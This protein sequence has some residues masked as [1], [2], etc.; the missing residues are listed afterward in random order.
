MTIRNKK[1]N[2]VLISKINTAILK[3]LTHVKPKLTTVFALTLILALCVPV[4]ILPLASAHSPAWKIQTWAYVAAAPNPVG[5]GQK[6]LI[7]GFSSMVLPSAAATNDI[8]FH[9]LQLKITKPDNTT[10]T[11]NLPNGDSTSTAYSSYTPD[12]VGTYSIIFTYPDLYFKWNDT[13]AL[14]TWTGDTFTGATSRPLKLVVQEEPLPQPIDSYP[15]PTEYWTRPIEGQNTYW[16]TVSSNWL[17]SADFS[18]TGSPSIYK[19]FQPD[20][21]APNSAHIM[22]T[23]PI[24]DG[25]IVGGNESAIPGNMFYSGSSYNNRMS[26]PIIMDGRLFY[27]VPYG[28]SATGNGIICRDLRTGEQIWYLNTTLSLGFGYYYAFEDMNQH[29]VIPNGWIFT[30]NFGYAIEPNTGRISNLNITGVPSGLEASGQAGE[31]LRYNINYANHWLGQWNSSKVFTAATSGTVNASL[32]SC[33]DFNVTIPTTIP[34][35]ST[36]YY[37]IIDDVLLGSNIAATY[38]PGANQARSTIDP[39]TVWAIS[40]RPGSRGQLLWQQSYAAPDGNVTRTLTAVDDV[41]RVFIMT[42]KETMQ[43]IGYSLDNGNKL[44]TTT[45]ENVANDYEFFSTGGSV[46][47]GRFYYSGYGGLLYCFDTK[48]GQLIYTYGNGGEGNSTYSGFN[49][50]WGNY[51]LSIFAIADGKVYLIT[52]EHSQNT[53]FYKDEPLICVDAFSG[54]EVWRIFGNAG[55]RTRAGC[56]VADGFFVYTNLYD[57]QVYCFGKGP[58]AMTVEAPSIA[59]TEGSTVIIRGFV[60][61]IAAGTKQNEQ[62]ARFPNGVPVVSDASQS[63][64]MEYVYM[65]K[66]KPTDA[67]GVPVTISVIDSNGNS[68]VIGNTTTNDGFFSLNWKPDISGQYTVHASFAGSESYWPSDAMTSF[69]VDAAAPT[70]APTQL[71]VQS[72]ADTYLL[73]GIAAIIVVMVIIGA[74]IMLMLRKRQ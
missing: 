12:Q 27:A 11:I 50:P 60:T 45:R 4:L 41:N 69:A 51:P 30:N 73:P 22:W 72:A 31:T 28:N 32:A 40:L 5:V 65:Q 43:W 49:G 15:L 9:D 20:G 53:P 1:R 35:D 44:W 3:P 18:S 48:N 68:R 26:K 56:A 61:D 38:F 33:Y 52:G 64:W 8:R 55:Y 13:S 36:T 42:D 17:G 29:G 39:Y 67:L 62:A 46:A 66:P 24:N 74:M 10:E 47:Y 23:V 19:D 6:V 7:V 16:Y 21:I 2:S 37:A 14:R 63:A 70:P 34:S 57:M 58:S 25:G 71:L 59:A 54:K